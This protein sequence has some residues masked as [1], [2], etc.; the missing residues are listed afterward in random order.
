MPP[1]P[2]GGV[3]RLCDIFLRE[4]ETASEPLEITVFSRYDKAAK[5]LAAAFRHTKFVWIH[6]TKSESLT[7]RAV[8]KLCEKLGSPPM[9][10]DYI[11]GVL[12][13]ISGS[14][15]DRVVLE[16][17]FEFARP[18]SRKMKQKPILHAHSRFFGKDRPNWRRNLAYVSK[19]LF[20]SEFLQNSAIKCGVPAEKCNIVRNCVDT[21]LFDAAHFTD[22]RKEKRAKYGISDDDI[23]AIFVGRLIPEKGAVELCK[24]LEQC[25]YDASKLKLL[26]VGSTDYGEDIHDDYRE[27]LDLAA[28]E[29]RVIF[30]GSV[31]QASAA[32]F[33][34]RAD[35][36]VVPSVYDEP[37]GLPVLEALSCGL[38]LIV[39]DAG[40]IGEYVG[41]CESVTTVPRGIGYVT[42]IAKALDKAANKLHN[43]PEWRAK[44]AAASR[45][46]ALEFDAA[47]YFEEILAAIQ[48]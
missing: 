5:E 41:D 2:G 25:E 44:A 27:Q 38:P 18:I 9:R 12:K 26:I 8:S 11:N 6:T 34:S 32:R 22:I 30:I 37:A 17:C 43:E 39:S 46:R 42:A 13:A 7:T 31:K 45:A 16:D 24:A 15:F 14:T 21:S 47:G 35:I 40:G 1:C 19:I 10:H 3:E 23:L 28:P 20:V 4:N 33:L 29:G 48:A 36:A